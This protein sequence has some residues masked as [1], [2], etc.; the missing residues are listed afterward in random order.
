MKIVVP[1]TE[2]YTDS[3]GLPRGLHPQVKERFDGVAEFVD[4]GKERT[5]YFELVAKLWRAGEPFCLIEQDVLPEIRDLDAL[6]RCDEPWCICPYPG[7]PWAGL[8]ID[9]LGCTRFNEEI[10]ASAPRLFEDLPYVTGWRDHWLGVDQGLARLLR[11]AGWQSHIHRTVPHL[12]DYGSD[13]REGEVVPPEASS[14]LRQLRR[15]MLRWPGPEFVTRSVMVGAQAADVGKIDRALL[16]HEM[17]S[18][19]D[20]LMV[21]MEAI[22]TLRRALVAASRVE[23]PA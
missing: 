18:A 5:E 20:N 6:E 2:S 14:A 13:P 9:C 12:R 8:L 19:E 21:A 23:V 15:T 3:D 7:P 4:V 1:F 10:M 16:F 17:G 11:R 22:R